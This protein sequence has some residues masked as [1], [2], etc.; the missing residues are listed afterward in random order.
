MF[1]GVRRCV[2]QPLRGC[3]CEITFAADLVISHLPT[4]TSDTA[5]VLNIFD[6]CNS[7]AN[8]THLPTKKIYLKSR[9]DD[10]KKLKGHLLTKK[11]ISKRHIYKQKNFFVKVG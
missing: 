2:G 8:G 10:L 11:D 3:W 7:T 4:L 9:K 6:M 1:S 5:K